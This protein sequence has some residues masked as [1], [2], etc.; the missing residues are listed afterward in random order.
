MLLEKSPKDIVSVLCAN[1][2]GDVR[3]PTAVGNVHLVFGIYVL[4]LKLG[5]CD[6]S[7]KLIKLNVTW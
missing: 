4:N 2:F 3:N 5:I 1:L 7:I 6:K